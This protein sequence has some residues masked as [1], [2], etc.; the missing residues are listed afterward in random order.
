MFLEEA[1]DM[2]SGWERACLLLEDGYLESALDDV[3]RHAHSLK[4]T[5][6]AVGFEVFA[7]FVHSV[8]EV[9]EA[10]KNRTRPCEGGAIKEL[11]DAHALI[12]EWV[13]ALKID[14][15]APKPGGP[16]PQDVQHD[17]PPQVV[18]A[19]ATPG[20]ATI[21]VA[22]ERLDQIVR[23]VGELAT[24]QAIVW[25]GR[26][27]DSLSAPSCDA[28]IQLMQKLLKDLQSSAMTLRLQPLQALFQRLE[29]AARDVA[30][31]QGKKVEVV[32]TGE[33]VELDRNVTEKIAESLVHIVRNCVDHGLEGEIDRYAA[34]KDGA[35]T[36][37]IDAS[38]QHG[39]IL[40]ELSDDGR[41]LNLDAI[42]AKAIKLGLIA[43]D[44][45]TDPDEI[46]RLVFAPGLSTA[47]A[48]TDVSGRGVGMDVVKAAVDALGG[49]IAIKTTL[50]QG[51][52]FKIRLPASLALV[53]ALI[54]ECAGAAFAVPLADVAEIIDLRGRT[55]QRFGAGDE[56]LIHRD[57]VVP[58]E[59]LSLRMPR[60]RAA[61]AL[62]A[63]SVLSPALVI[64][65]GAQSMA[66]AVD[67]VLGQNVV[68]ARQLDANLASLRG[69]EGGTILGNGDPSVILNLKAWAREALADPR[70]ANILREARPVVAEPTKVAAKAGHYAIFAVG[71]HRFAVP[72]ESL[73]EVTRQAML[74]LP[75]TAG[76][77][78]VAGL[79]ELRGEALPVI[80][81]RSALG[82]S[83]AAR[84]SNILL[85][86]E[87]RDKAAP[88]LAV[89]VDAVEAVAVALE[90]EAVTAFPLPPSLPWPTLG[91]GRYDGGSVVIVDLAAPF[92]AVHAPSP[93]LALGPVLAA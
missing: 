8:E 51:T 39:D 48:V 32:I 85:I 21:R 93:A 91:A 35:G 71:D 4:S 56:V 55:V 46:A 34:G 78:V 58:L 33:Q 40:L 31:T 36:L 29:R 3:G 68:H 26:E 86:V 43:A 63:D 2:L 18:G 6:M 22:A 14:R 42:R 16:A 87:P 5:A 28:A 74:P 45:S 64:E 27:T 52:S 44:G 81:A 19:T 60:S 84:E 77:T 61:A 12:T 66:F 25:H 83:L 75:A 15:A 69:L 37:R 54:V 47:R 79:A 13:A 41:G 7:H 88:L 59:R 65:I 76:A 38:Q 11:L 80:S 53:E 62:S 90:H 24:Q 73:R 9:I 10:L 82:L 1:A 72:I 49:D 17:V 89:A 23:L 57:R 67:R 50:G 70:V 30:R 20:A 92:G